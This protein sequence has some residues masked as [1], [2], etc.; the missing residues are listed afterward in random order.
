MRKPSAGAARKGETS[1]RHLG[2]AGLRALIA[3]GIVVMNGALLLQAGDEWNRVVTAIAALGLTGAFVV[4]KTATPLFRA[5]AS[6]LLLGIVSALLLYG[7]ARAL[8]LLP[9]VAA[10]CRYLISWRDGHSAAFLAA[11]VL[12][13]VVGEEI[14]WRAAVL[15]GLLERLRPSAAIA[16]ASALFAVAHVAAGVW[17]LP[18]AALG[19]GFVWNAF[20]AATGDLTA[21]FVSHL[22][23]D[24]LVVVVAPPGG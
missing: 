19:M 12:A 6:R 23:W 24:L 22:L 13:A 17:L 5:G 21:S 7:A 18:V 16:L 8:A 14:F 4:R 11:T 2:R 10:G 15:H 9:P 20:Y 3:A 1:G